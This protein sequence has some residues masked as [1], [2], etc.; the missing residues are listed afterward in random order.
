MDRQ[1]AIETLLDHYESPRNYGRLSDVDVVLSGGQPDCG[2]QVTIY[3]KVDATGEYIA[4]L[5]FE[6]T[7]CSVSQAAASIVTEMLQGAPLTW[8]EALECE[9][10]G[11]WLGHDVVRNRPRCATLALGTLKAAVAHYRAG[12]AP[13]ASGPGSSGMRDTGDYARRAQSE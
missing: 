5:T 11:D 10:L 12:H 3:L 8:V 2:D 13:A 7:G 1:R 6:G 9:T 4:G